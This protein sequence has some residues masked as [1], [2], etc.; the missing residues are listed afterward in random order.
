MAKWQEENEERTGGTVE[1]SDAPVGHC[2]PTPKGRARFGHPV[3][4]DTCP[5]IDTRCAPFLPY[6]QIRQRRE[7]ELIEYGP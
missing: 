4:Q 6:G 3:R 2:R 1:F 7:R 5:C